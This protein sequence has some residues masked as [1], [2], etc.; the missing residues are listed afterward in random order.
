MKIFTSF[1]VAGFL[2]STAVSYAMAEETQGWPSTKATQYEAPAKASTKAA[3]QPSTVQEPVSMTE[4]GPWTDEIAFTRSLNL[5][6]LNGYEGIS[7]L[8]RQG[9]TVYALA[10]K[11]GITV[12]ISVDLHSGEVK[13]LP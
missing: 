5:M 6:S 13:E 3:P 12:K 4:T 11:H 7:D 10:L 1:L 2:I 9:D 8:R